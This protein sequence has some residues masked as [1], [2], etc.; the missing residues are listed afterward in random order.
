MI[1]VVITEVIMA[2]SVVAIVGILM[3]IVMGYSV[4]HDDE[5]SLEQS[6]L[7]QIVC[8]PA[9]SVD[10]DGERLM[11]RTEISKMM[12]EGEHNI[13]LSRDGY[14][15]W[16]K[17]ISVRPGYFLRLKYPRL[18]KN[19]LSSEEAMKMPDNLKMKLFSPDRSMLL[20]INNDSSVWHIVPLKGDN[21]T[22]TD[23]DVTEMVSGEIEQIK[24]SQN[25]ER[26]LVKTVGETPEWVS[27]NIKDVNKSV[28]LTKEFALNFSEIRAVNDAADM[29][30]VVENGNL[31][32]VNLGSKE[33][34]G[35]LVAQV[36][37]FDNDK[38]KL[39]YVGTSGGKRVIGTYKKGENKTVRVKTITG[40]ESVEVA[41]EDYLGEM[42]LSYNIG[43]KFYSYKSTDFPTAGQKFK[44]K[45]VL[46]KD[47]KVLPS[48]LEAT[49]NGQFAV[50]K[51]GTDMA[52][53]DAETETV[54]EYSV[55]NTDGFWVDDY[56]YGEMVDGTLTV[57]DF[58]GTNERK[59]TK[60]ASYKAV[61]SANQKYIYYF[62]IDGK[63][64]RIKL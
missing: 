48:S 61:I 4:K 3:M 52:V 36:S 22:V 40:E 30:W 41:L 47:L 31:R 57:R 56:L 34:S 21:L 25:G 62:A 43:Q 10:V 33:V 29:L 23:V 14:D 58:D 20:Y 54:Y 60:K 64:M 27:V 8:T 39:V 5:W 53:F 2:V 16:E 38:D 63:L 19:D 37:S 24:W 35:V 12:A 55:N 26:I 17:T 7:V 51:T 59:L 42:Y 6:G 44:M 13:K 18:F 32:E 46:E 11:Q 45:K 50:M 1:R 28:N 9:A 49:P 15:T